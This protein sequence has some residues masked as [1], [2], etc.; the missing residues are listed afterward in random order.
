MPRQQEKLVA[1]A[2]APADVDEY[3]RQYE[4]GERQRYLSE[5]RVLTPQGDERWLS[6]RA[7]SV[8]DERTGEVIGSL[9]I[10]Q[11]ITERKRAERALQES[12]ERFRALIENASD[13]IITVDEDGIITFSSPS[14]TRVLGYARGE[15]V[16]RSAFDFVHPDDRVIAREALQRVLDGGDTRQMTEFRARAKDGSWRHVE[17]VA[18]VPD[19]SAPIDGVI[20]NYRDVTERRQ[21]EEHLQQTSKL[22]SI[23]TLAGGVAHDFNNVL[24]GIIGYADMLK[25]EEAVIGEHIRDVDKIRHLA[26]RAAG[27]TRQ[28]LLFSRQQPIEPVVLDPN[29]LVE[30]LSK[31][32]RRIISEDIELELVLAPDLGNVRADPGQIEQVL[33]NLAVNARD[34]MPNGGC[35]IIETANLFLDEGYADEHVGL[36]PG[37]YATISVS[38]TGCG[39][40]AET[41][42]RAFE[43]FFTT[44]EVGKGTGLGLATVYGIT[45]QHEGG[46]WVYSERGQGSTFK[47]YLPRVDERAREAE[48]CEEGSPPRGSETI[49]LVEDEEMVR[50]IAQQ[51]LE[52]RGYHVLSAADPAEAKAVFDQ[53]DAEI[54]LLLT[55]VVMPGKTGP[56]LHEWLKAN[57]PPLKVLFMSGYTEHAAVSR[58][59]LGGELPFLQKPFTPTAL[60]QK[61]REVLDA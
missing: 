35:L 32:L 15:A 39:M 36:E 53:H 31:M 59:L 27:L 57:R 55:D 46:I 4:A 18:S 58:D 28:L 21:L 8:R 7:V 19:E 48:A 44:K 5:L 54:A 61:V 17:A 56:G 10:L 25:T 23:G 24:T 38:D 1:E 22:Q 2:G 29:G 13:V 60:A 49:L 14:A 52:K 41:R 51:T 37:P 6:D 3:K 12:E 33:M 50:E 40:D 47:V 45:Q 26:D 42:R 30:N 9:G 20:I 34:A 43:P 16:G 11:D